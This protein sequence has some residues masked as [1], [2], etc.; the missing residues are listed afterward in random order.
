MISFCRKK[1]GFG[2]KEF[3]QNRNNHIFGVMKTKDK[4]VKAIG[5]RVALNI[6]FW[7]VVIIIKLPDLDDQHAFS[8]TFYYGMMLIFMALFAI[9]SYVNNLFLLPKYLFKGKRGKYFLLAFLWIVLMSFIYT[10]M[11]KWL[12][13]VFPGLNA[14]DVSIIMS[15]VSQSFAISE[16][17]NDMQTYFSIMLMWLMIFSLLGIYH[18]SI[19]KISR[20]EAAIHEHRE[21]ELR[22]LKNQ[23]NPHFLFNTLNNLYALSL[24][25]SSETPEAI[26]KL[27][28]VLRYLLYESN[29]QQVSFNM[30]KEVMLSYIDIELLRL[31]ANEQM[32][33]SVHTDKDYFIAPLLWLPV[34]EN[35]FKHTRSV[36]KPEIDFQFSIQQHHLRLFASNTFSKKTNSNNEAGGIGL[37]NLRKRLELLYPEKFTMNSGT[38]ENK[39]HIEIEIDLPQ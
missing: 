5:S 10:F 1:A 20:M 14:Y 31:P 37:N 11:M 6:Y 16:M 36:E 26:L 19:K 34:L 4:L 28:S 35:I 25:Q 2:R 29:D 32:Y 24:K 3:M 9:L 39:Y 15:P 13:M 38:N 30:E 33:F 12:P 27:S 18:H 23:I 22:F 21:A 17:F 7:V 8:N